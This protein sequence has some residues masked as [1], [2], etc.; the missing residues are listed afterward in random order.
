MPC[1]EFDGYIGLTPISA[2]YNGQSLVQA[3]YDAGLLPANEV[4]LDLNYWP[5]RNEDLPNTITFGG[6]PSSLMNRNLI[7]ID[8]ELIP[9]VV[10]NT[11]LWTFK[12]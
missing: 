12:L 1:L 11:V 7:S 5:G 10:P 4:T 2:L 8:A 9:A 6:V 3:M